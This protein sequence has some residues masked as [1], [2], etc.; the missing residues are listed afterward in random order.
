MAQPTVDRLEQQLREPDGITA[1]DRG[2][3]EPGYLGVVADDQREQGRGVR[4]LEVVADGP[5]AEAGS[6]RAT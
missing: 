2:P 6:A 3:A 5:A 4:I 1:P